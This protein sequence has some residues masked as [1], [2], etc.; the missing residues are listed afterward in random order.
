MSV[1][2]FCISTTIFNFIDWE[3]WSALA[4]LVFSIFAAA[5]L[6]KHHEAAHKNQ[7]PPKWDLPGRIFCA[8]LLVVV[9]TTVADSLGPVLSGL[10]APVPIFLVIFATFTHVQQGAKTT[11][12]L[13]RGVMVGS[14]GYATFYSIIGGLLTTLGISATYAL[15]TVSSL[16]VG[17]VTF[18]LT[19]RAREKRNALSVS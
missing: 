14:A 16:A 2:A 9:L 1:I 13:L 3:L 19:Q 5:N 12:N 7:A 8:T 10:I 4:L 15:A 17:G 18:L 6:V 11:S